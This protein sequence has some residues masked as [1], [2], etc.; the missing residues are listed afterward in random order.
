MLNHSF[1]TGLLP[2]SLREAN[3]S[4]ILKKG[5][6]PENCTSYRPISLLNL[7]LKVLSKVLATRLENLVPCITKEDQTGFIKGHSSCNNIRRLLNVIQICK[8]RAAD[9]LVVSLIQRRPSSGSNGLIYF[10]PWNNLV[11]AVISLNG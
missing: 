2:P 7:D 8:Q 3:I 9:G 4:L 5:K 6:C 1:D 11:S 10:L